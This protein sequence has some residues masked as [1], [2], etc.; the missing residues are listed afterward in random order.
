[1][2]VAAHPKDLKAARASGLKTAFVP[3]P[4]E[5]GPGKEL[6]STTDETF[7]VTASSFLELADKLL[8]IPRP[9]PRRRPSDLFRNKKPGSS[10]CNF[11]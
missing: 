5:H 4:L 3:R 6:A 8:W 10:Q 7:D 9:M 1:M 2:M 11:T